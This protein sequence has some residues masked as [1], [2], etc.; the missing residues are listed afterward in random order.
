MFGLPNPSQKCRWEGYG[1]DTCG[2]SIRK[3]KFR[4]WRDAEL[5]SPLPAALLIAS[6]A[7]GFDDFLPPLLPWKHG[8][9]LLTLT[10]PL[11]AIAQSCY[12]TFHAN[13]QRGQFGQQKKGANDGHLQAT[14]FPRVY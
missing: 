2:Q 9:K 12:V 11:G 3:R 7:E 13:I 14:S 10:D 5:P 1:K 6:R 4:D 8:G